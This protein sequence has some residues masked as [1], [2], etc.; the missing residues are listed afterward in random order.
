[1]SSSSSVD[2]SHL[3]NSDG[4]VDNYNGYSAYDQGYGIQSG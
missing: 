2:N 4:F 1:M 3:F